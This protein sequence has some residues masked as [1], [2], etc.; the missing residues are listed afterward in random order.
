MPGI[1]ITPLPAPTLIDLETKPFWDAA[2]SGQL[3]LGYCEK[4]SQ[5][6]YFPRR[7][8][9][10]CFAVDVEWKSASGKGKI[11]SYSVLRVTAGEPFAIAYVTLDEGPII[12]T[13]I[14][15]AAFEDIE[16]DKRVVVDF[17]PTK[18]DV[19][20]PVFRLA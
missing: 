6:H 14:V 13:T 8:C 4:C 3:L 9:P 5:Y 17:W 11:Y 10:F 19:K 20:A 7:H 18:G 15:D 2:T 12:T 1:Y 16:I